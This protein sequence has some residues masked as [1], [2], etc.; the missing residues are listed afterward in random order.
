MGRHRLTVRGRLAITLLAVAT[1]LGGA[2]EPASAA[3]RVTGAGPSAARALSVAAPGGVSA[4]GTSCAGTTMTVQVSWTPSGSPGI[5]GYPVAIRA[6]TGQ[7]ATGQTNAQSTTFRQGITKPNAATTVSVT[8]A[9]TTLT[10]YGWTSESAPAA[11]VS[12]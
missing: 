1:A 10:A 9:V 3:W 6:S 5:R 11:A 4:G 12:C 8:A 7:T 2:P